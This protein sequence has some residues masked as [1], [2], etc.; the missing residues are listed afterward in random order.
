MICLITVTEKLGQTDGGASTYL[1]TPLV[2]WR[3]TYV[4]M[5][6]WG[7]LFET[8]WSH[9]RMF[10]NVRVFCKREIGQECGLGWQTRR[11]FA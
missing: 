11:L 1:A 6:L 2:D 10:R 9:V 5:S 4:M 8:Y 7:L 3:N